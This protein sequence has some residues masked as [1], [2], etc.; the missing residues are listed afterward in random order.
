MSVAVASPAS[1]AA[2]LRQTRINT[3]SAAQ[4]YAALQYDSPQQAAQVLHHRRNGGKASASP[5]SQTT[6]ASAARPNTGGA[7]NILA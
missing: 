3:S 5:N 1:S 4:A 6:Q 2:P 7:L